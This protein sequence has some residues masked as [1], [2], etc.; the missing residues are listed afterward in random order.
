VLRALAITM[1]LMP[2]VVGCAGEEERVSQAERRA[3]P[4]EQLTLSSDLCPREAAS[5]R[6]P[7]REV[8]RDRAKGRRQLAALT[9]AYRK[10]PEAKVKTTYF[11]SDEGDGSED[12]TVRE[13]ARSHLAGAT[14]D[15]LTDAPCFKRVARRLRALVRE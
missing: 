10:H 5:M 12:L 6:L 4:T 7:A 8:R 11:S 1:A 15:G 9:A 14:E 3:L 2:F 13:L